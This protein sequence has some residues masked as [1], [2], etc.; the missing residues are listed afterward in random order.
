MN[1][2]D[3]HGWSLSAM[4]VVSVA[5]PALLLGRRGALGAAAG[6]MT[7]FTVMFLAANWKRR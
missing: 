4:V 3:F 6:F 5:V 7:M 2:R 1:R